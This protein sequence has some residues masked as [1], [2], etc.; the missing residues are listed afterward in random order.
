[1]PPL[2]PSLLSSFMLPLILLFGGSLGCQEIPADNPFDPESTATLQA[3][4]SLSLVIAFPGQLSRESL[5]EGDT[6][7]LI[8]DRELRR[9]ANAP[10]SFR[11]SLL[12]EAEQVSPD[13]DFLLLQLQFNELPPGLY[14]L[15]ARVAG[16]VSSAGSRVELSIA[17]RAF[18]ELQLQREPPGVIAGAIQLEGREEGANG[19]VLV[20]V[21]GR[22]VQTISYDD[23]RFSLSVGAGNHQLRFSAPGYRAR[24]LEERV[25]VESGIEY[26]LSAPVELS[27]E[28]AA[29]SGQLLLLDAEGN[30]RP[31]SGLSILLRRSPSPG[32][33]PQTFEVQTDAEGS[34]SANQLIE[35]LWGISAQVDGYQALETSARVI[36][37]E[38]LVLPSF[39]LAPLQRTVLGVASRLD[40]RW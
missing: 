25:T 15:R 17:E 1:M 31:A 39:S 10:Q 14:W 20:T 36:P 8:S 19:G 16:F 33:S 30:A 22:T 40:P 37:G 26:M 5:A 35:G 13:E 24:L 7:E 23:G 12:A 2:R 18:A 27:F 11:S 32:F 21:E 29:L 28:P 34:F 38:S 9:N 4:A 3:P 6:I